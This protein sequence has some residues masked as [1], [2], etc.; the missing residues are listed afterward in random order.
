[1]YWHIVKPE[2]AIIIHENGPHLG[3]E[4]KISIQRSTFPPTHPSP[5][6]YLELWIG[7]CIFWCGSSLFTWRTPSHTMDYWAKLFEPA[8]DKTYNKTSMTSKDSYQ[9]V[10][11]F[12]MAGVLV[13]P[14]LARPE[15][16][17]GRCV[18]RRLIRLHGCTG[19]SESMLVARLIVGFVVCWLTCH[20][21]E[22][23]TWF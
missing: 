10:H 9:P 19:W 7:I 5:H 21:N 11:S 15:A 1:M 17:E 22:R 18:Q 14:S 23:T 13:Y 20:I 4:N 12:S 2:L 16:V 6:P 8:Y 3:V